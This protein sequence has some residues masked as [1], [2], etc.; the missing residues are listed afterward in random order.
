MKRKIYYLFTLFFILFCLTFPLACTENKAYDKLNDKIIVLFQQ[1]KYSEAEK[2]A[3]DALKMA[4]GTYGDDHLK[5]AS[6]LDTLAM[7]YV[8]QEKYNRIE[9]LN[10]DALSIKKKSLGENH[11]EVINHLEKMV[12]LYQT[13]GKTEEAQKIKAGIEKKGNQ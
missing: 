8:A 13:M 11:Q 9:P 7:I 12:I 1:G 3:Q 5:V 4:K 2:L 10:K 6:S